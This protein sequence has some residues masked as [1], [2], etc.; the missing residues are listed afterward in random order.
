M[1]VLLEKVQLDRAVKASQRASL[2]SWILTALNVLNIAFV[3]AVVGPKVDGVS[4]RM[5]LLSQETERNR[6]TV[7]HNRGLMEEVKEDI[8]HS[9]KTADRL[10]TLLDQA[11]EKAK[12]KAKEVKDGGKP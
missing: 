2:A 3:A 11:L 4:D 1:T 7:Q 5:N 8:T 9:R 12:S 10:N 6:E